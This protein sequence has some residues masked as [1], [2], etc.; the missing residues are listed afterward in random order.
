VDAK[1]GGLSREQHANTSHSGLWT[2]FQILIIIFLEK[3][4]CP[5]NSFASLESGS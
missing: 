2:D 4:A 1:L 5:I 3:A